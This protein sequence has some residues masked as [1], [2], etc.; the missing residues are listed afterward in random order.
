MEK[1]YIILIPS[2]NELTSLK[3]IYSSIN[4]SNLNCLI[5]DDSSTD[6]THIWLKRNNATFLRNKRKLG[7]EK[8]L[9]TGFKYISK[10]FNYNYI[11]TFDA[12]GEH[13]VKDLKRIIQFHKKTKPDILICNRLSFN[14]WSEYL[15]S[16][17]FNQ[18]FKIKD[19]LSGLKIYNLIKLSKIIKEIKKNMYLVDIIKIFKNKNYEIKNYEINVNKRIGES[20]VGKDLIV[21]LKILSLAKLIF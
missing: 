16:F 19:P 15:L 5:I 9:I 14:R 3:K 11:I 1:N 12:D 20:K 21:N 7:Y 2:H 17:I 4:K 18:I 13:K 10:K 6:N 8:S